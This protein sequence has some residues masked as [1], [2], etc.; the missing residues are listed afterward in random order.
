MYKDQYLV[1]MPCQKLSSNPQRTS[2]RQALNGGHSVV[3][4]R[5]AVQHHE[6]VAIT[7]LKNV[8]YS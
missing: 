2:A 8:Q 1:I 6:H 5:R 7:Q 4:N 3:F